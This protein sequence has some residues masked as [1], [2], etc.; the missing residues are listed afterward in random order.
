[1]RM[2]PSRP[3][4]STV[5]RAEL[6]VFEMLSR[7]ADSSSV[8]LH[9]LR[10]PVH[11]RKRSTEADFVIVRPDGVLVLEVKG[12]RVGRRGGEWVFTDRNDRESISYEGP[13]AQAEGAMHSLRRRLLMSLGDARLEG[14]PFGFAVITPDCTIP[15]SDVEWDRAVYIDDRQSRDVSG[16]ER[17]LNR[18]M[19]FWRDK[20]G[21]MSSESSSRDYVQSIIDACRPDFEA[22]QSLAG[23]LAS[24]NAE[25]IRLTERQ[26]GALDLVADWRRVIVEGAAG[27]G[28]TV[29]ALE[30]ARRNCEA[31][32]ST[33]LTVRSPVLAASLR[34]S[35]PHEVVVTPHRALASVRQKVDVLVC[36]EAQDMMTEEDLLILDGLLDGGIEH[37]VWTAFMDSSG[38]RGVLG[39]FDPEAFSLLRSYA[40]GPPI[41]LRQNI[42]NTRAVADE[43][44][45]VTGIPGARPV[46]ESPGRSRTRFVATP[47]DEAAVIR[48]L[49]RDL[50]RDGVEDSAITVLTPDGSG[51]FLAELPKDFRQSLSSVGVA[52]AA[53]WPPRDLSLASIPDFKGM[54]NDVVILADLWDVDVTRDATL[55]YTGMSRP[56]V[57]LFVV[58]PEAQREAVEAA[59]VANVRIWGTP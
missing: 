37:G 47:A 50:R 19:A 40:D 41:V 30:S 2:I 24:V 38:Q 29:V 35:L 56:R 55:L 11:V 33:L 46:V 21:M 25:M 13:F 17:S 32:R 54:E 34:R 57:D 14:H 18:V 1:M 49:I 7:V 9:S 28:K 10:L 59:K 3:V 15:S 39:G 4:E 51:R 16:L 27:T 12:G 52:S 26:L 22:V 20:L 36:D 6:R 31:G 53:S 42:R 5:S 23:V 48:S 44:A 43:T 58:W 45:L 8:A